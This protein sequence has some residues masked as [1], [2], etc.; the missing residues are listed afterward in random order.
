MRDGTSTR[1][2]PICS[3]RCAVMPMADKIGKQ[4]TVEICLSIRSISLNVKISAA[5]TNQG[6]FGSPKSDII[7]KRAA[8]HG[9]IYS[10]HVESSSIHV[11]DHSLTVQPI[12]SL[13]DRRAALRDR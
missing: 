5:A 11:R 8:R 10:W 1:L 7:L 13:A 6:A 2:L 12:K 3:P 4:N 9:F